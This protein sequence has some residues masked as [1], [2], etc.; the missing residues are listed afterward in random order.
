MAVTAM[1]GTF[2]FGP[3]PA[4]TEV[5][6]EYYRHKVTQGDLGIMDDIRLGVPEVG[7]RPVPTFPYKAGVTV[8]GGLSLQP[9]LENTVGW[10]LRGLMG[11]YSVVADAP[12]DFDAVYAAG[13]LDGAT[14]NEAGL[15]KPTEPRYIEITVVLE[16]AVAATPAKDLT[17]TY[18]TSKNICFNLAGLGA[19]THKFY[20]N[21]EVTCLDTLVKPTIA[22]ANTVALGYTG[23]GD[24]DAD[25]F[26]THTFCMKPSDPSYIPWLTFRKHIPRK[27][28]AAAT[29]LGEIYTD[30]K[31]LNATLGLPN[32]APITMRT[33]VLGR[34]FTLDH[35]PDAWTYINTFEDYQSIPIGCHTS[36]VFEIPDGTELPVVAATVGFANA[37]LDIR[38]ERVFG[39]PFIEDITVVQRALTFDILVKW[40]NPDLYATIVTGSSVGT[41]WGS[42]PY[43]GSLDVQTF[44]QTAIPGTSPAQY[45]ALQVKAP[46]VMLAMNG[47]IVLA[48]NQAVM[49]RFTGTALDNT[50]EYAEFILK[51]KTPAYGWPR[52]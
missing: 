41:T 38:Q 49:M 6:T 2:S 29:D 48:S 35:A 40:N 15:T 16:A 7:G 23:D 37:P 26:F 25:N 19:G 1:T 36:G 17:I 8:G 44:A 14:I 10:L 33:D 30:C 12:G 20:I 21:E 5:A 13:A 31:I 39:D 34:S 4:K 46:S 32:D 3:Q 47:P 43:V 9:R 42:A 50:G 22:G 18:D 28:D 52:H 24:A 45:Y 11:D 27:E 51:N